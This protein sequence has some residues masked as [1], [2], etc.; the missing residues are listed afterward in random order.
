MNRI[1]EI[2]PFNV[3]EYI[4]IDYYYEEKIDDN[5]KIEIF[6]RIEMAGSLGLLNNL[7][8]GLIVQLFKENILYKIAYILMNFRVDMYYD[9]KNESHEIHEDIE[10]AFKTLSCHMNKE[11]EYFLNKISY[12]I[13][14]NLGYWK[15]VTEY[16]KYLS[17]YECA[18][19]CSKKHLNTHH[20]KYDNRGAEYRNLDDLIV[21]CKLCHSKHHGRKY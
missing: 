4:L 17:N 3:I 9:D 14:L 1:I 8:Y 6:N 16:K 5:K 21:I 7:E 18:L 13:F 15:V 19:C 2:D 11:T 12:D 10:N 20:K